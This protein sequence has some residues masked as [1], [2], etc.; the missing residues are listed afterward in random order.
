MGLFFENSAVF[1]PAGALYQADIAQLNNDLGPFVRVVGDDLP[2]DPALFVKDADGHRKEAA[3]TLGNL[4]K[5]AGYFLIKLGNAIGSKKSGLVHVVTCVSYQD[6]D[7]AIEAAMVAAVTED[8]W[9]ARKRQL[10][11]RAP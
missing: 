5:H 3:F 6:W 2:I 8:Y 7:E 10:E 1:P 11:G 9:L 4:L